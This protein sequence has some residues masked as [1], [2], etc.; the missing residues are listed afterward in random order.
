MDESVEKLIEISETVYRSYAQKLLDRSL[1][2][3]NTGL[4]ASVPS[5]IHSSMKSPPLTSATPQAIE[6]F[7]QRLVEELLETVVAPEPVANAASVEEEP[8]TRPV[9]SVAIIGGGVSGLYAAMMLAG[10]YG[11][12]VDVIEASDRIGGR[13]YTHRFDNNATAPSGEWDYF[14]SLSY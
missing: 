7:S 14:V 6:E 13:L 2:D 11:F 4:P 9:D 12:K 10:N 5:T 8:T 1:I 3:F